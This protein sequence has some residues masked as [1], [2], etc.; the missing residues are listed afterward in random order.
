MAVAPNFIIAELDQ[1]IE[2]GAKKLIY[3]GIF[4][5]LT[6][7]QTER[8]KDVACIFEFRDAD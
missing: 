8:E 2:F 6:G 4:Q 1:A 7:N 3:K 5:S